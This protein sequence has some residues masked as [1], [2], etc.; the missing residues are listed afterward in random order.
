MSPPQW[1]V[2][3]FDIDEM[4]SELYRRQLQHRYRVVT[5]F[6]EQDA[7]KALRTQSIDAIVLEPTALDDETWRFVIQVRATD[8]YRDAPII[9]CSSLD[10]R[11]R[12]AE[13]GVNAYLI[14]PVS[15]QTLESILATVFERAKTPLPGA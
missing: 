4:T 6:H 10:A 8:A 2:L 14:K 5:C 15:P 11:R 13:L 12:G 7:W 9:I 1:T 3:I